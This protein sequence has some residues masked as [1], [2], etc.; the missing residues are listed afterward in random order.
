M[1]HQLIDFLTT[2]AVPLCAVWSM[3][4]M[5]K[6]P[7]SNKMN[8]L[9]G[10]QTN[11]FTSTCAQYIIICKY[12]AKLCCKILCNNTPHSCHLKEPKTAKIMRRPQWNNWK[13]FPETLWNSNPFYWGCLITARWNVWLES[14]P[15][16]SELE[17]TVRSLTVLQN[18]SRPGIKAYKRYVCSSDNESYLLSSVQEQPQLNHACQSVL[19]YEILVWTVSPLQCWCR[20]SCTKTQ[21]CTK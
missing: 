20:I 2:F 3:S 4:I 9:Y 15:L 18:V 10:K 19:I 21:F 14:Y 6:H 7:T 11:K 8:T 13:M 12:F 16:R 1:W 17:L 5:L